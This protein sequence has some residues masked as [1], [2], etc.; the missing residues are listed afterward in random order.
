M[1]S[2]CAALHVTTIRVYIPS[3]L[4]Y[5]SSKAQGYTRNT[6]CTCF[7]PLF[8]CVVF[9]PFSLFNS[10]LLF[11]L[12]PFISTF[13]LIPTLIPTFKLLL[14]AIK[15]RRTTVYAKLCYKIINNPIS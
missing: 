1:G 5:S 14:K 8:C 4:P 6:N 13:T 7:Y 10:L 3:L 12:L 15:L 2:R 9:V 11:A